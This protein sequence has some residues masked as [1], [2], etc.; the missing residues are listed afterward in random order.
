MATIPEPDV[1]VFALLIG[2][3]EIDHRPAD[4]AAVSRQH[5]PRKFELIA[6]SAGLAQITSLRGFWLEKWSFGLADG[7][8]I[9]ITAGRR[10]RKLL[11]QDSVRT[12][13]L[14]PRSKRAGV[15][16][17]SAASWY[18]QSGHGRSEAVDR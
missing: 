4:C 16:Q 18:R 13:Q 6:L 14:P 12:G 1:V 11:R 3:P 15:E 7:R 17:K 2:M 5:K 10:G 8:F 9:A